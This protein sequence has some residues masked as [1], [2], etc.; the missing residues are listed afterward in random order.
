MHL[1]Y[2]TL[3]SPHFNPIKEAFSAIKAWIWGNQNYAQGE[4]SGEE[5]ANPYTMIWESVFMTVTCNKVAGWYHDFGY[6]TN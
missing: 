1:V 3:Y 6:L 2:L 5:T 4:L